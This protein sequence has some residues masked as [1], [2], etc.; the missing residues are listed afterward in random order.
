MLVVPALR[1]TLEVA[2]LTAYELGVLLAAILVTWLLTEAI[3]R[4]IP[5]QA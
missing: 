1:E 3:A 5:R 2:E 4:L